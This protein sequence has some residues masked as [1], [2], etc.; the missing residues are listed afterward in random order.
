MAISRRSL[1][2]TPAAIA[3]GPTPL[4][5]SKAG[6]LGRG[7]HTYEFGGDWGKL[8][9]GHQYGYTHGV[10]MD[11]QERIIIH[12]RSKDA[13]AIFDHDGKFVKSWGE[14]F[15]NGAHGLLL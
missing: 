6:T 1:L 10:V 7:K 3:T 8:P 5:G 4:L 14:D 12:N 11:S 15:E 2:K 9:N 13:V